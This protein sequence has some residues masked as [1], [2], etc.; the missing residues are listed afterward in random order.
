MTT[1]RQRLLN[2]ARNQDEAEETATLQDKLVL[3]QVL[4]SECSSPSQGEEAERIV[5]R[6][7]ERI[8]RENMRD[9]TALFFAV[10]WQVVLFLFWMCMVFQ[11]WTTC[12]LLGI[13]LAITTAALYVVWYLPL[14]ELRQEEEAMAAD[15]LSA[16]S[17]NSEENLEG[18]EG[19]EMKTTGLDSQT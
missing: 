3:Q 6:Y 18:L 17:T 9:M 13:A 7:L 15:S 12:I 19:Y 14:E 11:T 10:P 5:E 4:Q 16:T 2:L 8:D 1:I